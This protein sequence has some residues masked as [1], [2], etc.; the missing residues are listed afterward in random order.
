MVRPLIGSCSFKLSNRLEGAL[1]PKPVGTTL[2]APS[3]VRAS[4]TLLIDDVGLSVLAD[5]AAG[6][7]PPAS[8]P[9]GAG[10]AGTKLVT[11]GG[12]P[13][14]A[15]GNAPI[16]TALAKVPPQ[17]EPP[18]AAAPTDGA[19]ADAVAEAPAEE[20]PTKG[21]CNKRPLR[22]EIAEVWE[23]ERK[24]PGSG[25]SASN[26]LPCD[27]PK[28]SEVDAS[29]PHPDRVQ[30]VPP[31][32]WR[33]LPKKT[34]EAEKGWDW[35]DM[36]WA[37]EDWGYAVNFEAGGKFELFE[38][39]MYDVIRRRRWYRTRRERPEPEP[40]K[41]GPPSAAGA[42]A[43]VKGGNTVTHADGKTSTLQ[44][45]DGASLNGATP[46]MVT[47]NA[48]AAGAVSATSAT[49]TNNAIVDADNKA[50]KAAGGSMASNT[51]SAAAAAGEDD[52]E[53]DD[54]D[55]DGEVV[56]AKV[57]T[58]AEH[59]DAL[60]QKRN[61]KEE[62]VQSGIE[63]C[64][65]RGRELIGSKAALIRE[66]RQ[67]QTQSKWKKEVQA[68][69]LTNKANLIGVEKQ[70][71]ALEEQLD[72]C[73]AALDSEELSTPLYMLSRRR[74]Y[75]EAERDMRLSELPYEKFE[76][77]TGQGAHEH[78]VATLKAMVA[79]LPE[80]PEEG[81]LGELTDQ[82]QQVVAV[83]TTPNKWVVRVYILRALN[84]LGPKDDGDV[85]AYVKV[86]LGEKEVLNTRRRYIKDCFNTASFFESIELTDVTIPG[87]SL[88]TVEVCISHISMHLPASPCTTAPKFLRRH[89]CSPLP[90]RRHR[91]PSPLGD[92]TAPHPP[93]GDTWLT[94]PFTSLGDTW[95]VHDRGVIEDGFVGATVIDLEDRI[96]SPLFLDP[97]FGSGGPRPPLE[98]RSL[99]RP[100]FKTP[101][102]NVEMWCEVLKPI[103]VE[104][105]PMLDIKPPEPQEWELRVIIWKVRPRTCRALP[106]PTC[107][108]PS[109][110]LLHLW[111]LA[112]CTRVPLTRAVDV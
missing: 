83:L 52:D 21:R 43:A 90:W 102:G 47:S 72:E 112:S 95:Q 24:T 4:P 70:I 84:M 100:D 78:P 74:V 107:V 109:S 45:A 71:R 31:P 1:P 108:G 68:Q 44:V 6:A 92:A 13:P 69:K 67:L 54:D 73:E 105:S 48:A 32:Q 9:T 35:V 10:E 89:D 5:T 56:P 39:G 85:D 106:L 76:V 58:P 7:V 38:Q 94:I 79:L 97:S 12:R 36:Y 80:V 8:A 14:S 19:E 18:A 22:V 49:T 93:L 17:A 29:Q 3:P 60:V 96:Y 28:W 2:A 62:R 91:S 11:T 40:V 82:H 46:V 50:V 37:K 33:A 110:S 104:D 65:A 87:D 53:D 86:R 16:S 98:W 55:D 81:M 111:L 34:V 26:L 88:I 30:G 61:E 77:V 20:E 25:W 75:H 63:E 15:A 42:T 23:N 41:V 64:E 103:A 27:P 57:L 66:K 101:T 51:P 99:Y 59:L